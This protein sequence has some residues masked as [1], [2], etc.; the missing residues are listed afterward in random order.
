MIQPL[1][2]SSGV[3]HIFKG[4]QA[5][6]IKLIIGEILT[7]E[8]I[9]L[10][11]TGTIQIK[12]KDRI[13][14]AQMQREIPLNRGDTVFVKVE[15]PLPDGA[16]PLRVLSRA[17]AESLKQ[18][19]QQSQREIPQR[20]LQLLSSV[21]QETTVAKEGGVENQS[22]TSSSERGNLQRAV[23]ATERE[24][25]ITDSDFLETLRTA[26]SSQVERLPEQLKE[27]LVK[28]VIEFLSQTKTTAQSLNEFIEV[29]ESNPELRQEVGK[30]KE[31]LLNSPELDAQKLKRVIA[32]TGVLF[33]AK[34]RGFL[35]EPIKIVTLKDDLKA[36]L[37]RVIQITEGDSSSPIKERAESLLRQIES[38]QVISKNFQS[39]FTFLPFFSAQVE[40]GHIGFKS[41]RRE[42]KDFHTVFVSLRF[43]EDNPLSFVV[44]MINRSIFVSFSA[45]EELLE[46]IRAREEELRECF[47]RSQLNLSGVSYHRKIDDLIKQWSIKEGV[48]SLTV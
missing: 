15:K 9:D 44:T 31:L 34:L 47:M 5:E 19:I 12:I 2:D 21:F 20:L 32:Q 13:L 43:G 28:R 33:E 36:L 48:V 16:I 1:Q 24:L 14:N 25:K 37:H 11:S 8:I 6:P 29:A 40:G 26:L 27:A 10:F 39:L 18:Q 4:K 22:A 45:K 3:I 17:E 7:A 30:L 35:N 42:G 41:L 38:Y 46:L 23:T